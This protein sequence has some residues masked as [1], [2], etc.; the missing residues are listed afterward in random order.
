AYG[1]FRYNLREYFAEF[2]G[3]LILV[4]FGDGAV[5]LAVTNANAKGSGAIIISLGFAFALMLAVFIASPV[6]G[7]HVNPAITLANALLRG[8][9]WKKVPGYMF[10]QLFGAFCG[11]CLVMLFNYPAIDLFDG[12]IRA[13][14]GNLATAGIFATYPAPN[15]TIANAFFIEMLSTTFLILGILGINDERHGTPSWLAPIACG[16]TI[17]AISF[18]TGWLTGFA[19]NPARDMG[20]RLFTMAAGW[21]TEPFTAAN[22]YFWVPLIAP[23]F[24]AIFGIIVYDFF[25]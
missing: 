23:F 13:T 4:T 3:T 6:S 22:H 12:G 21:G 2:L 25:I 17:G 24:G 1:R 7:A 20:P 19:L 11:A 16:F 10:A 14:S 8:F 18:S 15:V 5:A 9:P